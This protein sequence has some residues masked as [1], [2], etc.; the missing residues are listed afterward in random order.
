VLP[1][2][3]SVILVVVCLLACLF[4][5]VKRAG[6]EAAGSRKDSF[7]HQI[8]ERLAPGEL[9]LLFRLQMR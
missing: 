7:R 2:G 5:L 8:L 3:N 4:V 6:G 9:A 1:P